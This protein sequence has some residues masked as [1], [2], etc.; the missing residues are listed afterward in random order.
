MGG[1]LAARA[2]AV[3]H[4]DTADAGGAPERMGMRA[5]L[6]CIRRRRSS[7]QSEQPPY[8]PLFAAAR[9]ATSQRQAVVPRIQ[10]PRVIAQKQ[11]VA[12]WKQEQAREEPA[13][14]H[15]D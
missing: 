5:P 7:S 13:L 11:T 14:P 8:A 1:N 15:H 9:T 2:L 12:D 3:R 6:R 4:R 10:A